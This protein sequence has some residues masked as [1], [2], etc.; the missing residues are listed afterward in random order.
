MFD[1]IHTL[2]KSTTGAFLFYIIAEEEHRLGIGSFAGWCL[3][4]ILGSGYC[5]VRYLV[6]ML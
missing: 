5:K 6:H 2:E 1:Y 3:R 4:Q